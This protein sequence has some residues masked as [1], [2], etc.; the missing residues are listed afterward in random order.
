M[1]T[2]LFLLVIFLGGCFAPRY[3]PV[4]GK[5]YHALAE[6]V[7]EKTSHELNVKQEKGRATLSALEE[8][9]N[10]AYRVV[11]DRSWG[12]SVVAVDLFQD[13]YAAEVNG[14]VEA[15]KQ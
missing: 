1:R 9:G 14:A 13:A 3:S 15:C 7:N 8:N 2:A 6:C 5:D 12:G 10:L 11:I 4:P